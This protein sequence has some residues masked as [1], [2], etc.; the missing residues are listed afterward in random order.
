[1]KNIL[2][3]H[4]IGLIWLI[5]AFDIWCCQVLTVDQEMNPLARI[6]MANFGVWTMVSCKV[7]GTF[8]VTEVLRHLPLYYSIII[9]ATMVGLVLV[10]TGVIPIA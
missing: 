4:L 8:I 7:V 2:R 10:L 3:V 5:T 9:A 1:M 6:I